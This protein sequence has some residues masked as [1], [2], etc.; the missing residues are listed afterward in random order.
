MSEVRVMPNQ[1]SIDSSFAPTFGAV[2]TILVAMLLVASPAAWLAEN[3]YGADPVVA[4]NFIWVIFIF[5]YSSLLILPWLNL[6]GVRDW[7]KAQRLERM[8]IVWLCLIVGP[9]LLFELPWVAFYPAIMAGKGQLWAYA[10]WSYFDGGDVR[11]VTRDVALVSMETGAS[12]IG[13][14][15]AILLIL[16][17]KAGRFSD[18][19][20]LILMALMV[21]DFYPTYMYYATEIERGFPSV[22]GVTNL[23]IKFLGSNVF[24]LVMPWV[25]FIWAG[26]QLM[27]HRV[28][29]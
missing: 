1:G 28:T 17:R 9:H 7:S 23:L 24:W 15:A 18:T 16:R 6:K 29:R 11:Y 5:V 10:W 27:A 20:L 4:S 26:R 2:A 21:A 13:I 25:V 19:Q 14:V 22:D 3:R 8:C 12:I